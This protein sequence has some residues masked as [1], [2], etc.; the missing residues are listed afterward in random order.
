MIMPLH[1]VTHVYELL[2]INKAGD[3]W[4]DCGII[5]PL[6]KPEAP[7]AIAEVE[8]AAFVFHF[9]SGEINLIGVE[10]NSQ[11]RLTLGIHEN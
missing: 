1:S 3:T 6:S 9:V 2:A 10:S 5:K 8:R 4:Q 7:V 11:I